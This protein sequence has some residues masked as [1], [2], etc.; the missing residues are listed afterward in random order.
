MAL[1][2]ILAAVCLAGSLVLI[3]KGHPAGK[4][5]VFIAGLLCLLSIVLRPA[6]DEPDGLAATELPVSLPQQDVSYGYVSSTVCRDCHEDQHASWAGS[7]HRTMT[8]VVTPETMAA[9]AVQVSLK[10]HTRAFHFI[11]AED[12][13]LVE[14]VDPEWDEERLKVGLY[15]I[16]EN[17]APPFV[18][19]QIVMSTGSHHYQ[20]YWINGTKG[21]QLW[22]VPWVYHIQMQRWI[23]IQDT[24]IVPPFNHR[25]VSNWNDNC[26]HCHSAGG[27]PGVQDR[28]AL[29][30][31]IGEL[32]IACEACHGPG[33]QH[34]EH[35][36][37]LIAAGTPGSVPDKTIVNP[38]RLSHRRSAEVCGQCHSSTLFDPYQRKDFLPGQMLEDT[39]VLHRYTDELVQNTSHLKDSFWA[40]GTMRVAGRDFSSLESSA[41]YQKGEVTCTSCHSMHRY[42]DADD[43]LAPSMRTDAACLQCHESFAM[44]VSA[45]SHHTLESSGSRCTN[46][47]MPHTSFGLF[48]AIRSHR[49]DSPTAAMTIKNGR[50]NAC[51]L[52]HLDRTM[53]WIDEKLVEWYGHE[54]S[55][56]SDIANNSSPA[57]ALLLS[58][59][60]VQRAVMAWN[61]GRDEA[62]EA[63]G[64]QWQLPLL[65]ELLDDPYSVVR[66]TAQKSIMNYPGTAG[67]EYDF[68]APVGERKKARAT[69]IGRWEKHRAA[70]GANDQLARKSNDEL[71]PLMLTPS[72]HRDVER[73][74]KLLQVRN[75]QEI[76]LSE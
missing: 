18:R 51:V 36:R 21:N 12:R 56:T 9:P 31:R 17:E 16:S 53:P 67:F 28:E 1:S 8:Q 7:F 44:D 68:L 73:L 37:Q 20:T 27:E 48:K 35:R 74:S 33:Q 32:G 57:V 75:N 40:D 59:D 69:L 62:R 38:L 55:S 43:Q 30:T 26:I 61:F 11:P 15:T 70:V 54:K 13:F 65:A 42:E 2:G 6:D 50:P 58:G 25:D 41:C 22:R 23:P 71:K 63:S 5:G 24:F 29:E 3:R 64:D 14:T 49:I 60:A 52:C 10:L 39:I 66:V 19:R 72:R 76:Y 46:C 34:V 47:H 45:H 4:L